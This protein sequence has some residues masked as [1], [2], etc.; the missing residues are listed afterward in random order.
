MEQ[1]SRDDAECCASSHMCD[2]NV[3]MVVVY[4]N[5]LLHDFFFVC[6]FFFAPLKSRH[7]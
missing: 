3:C 6:L 4:I 7:Y 1:L 2:A 5:R